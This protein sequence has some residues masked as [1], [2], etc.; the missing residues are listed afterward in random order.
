[1]LRS[2]RGPFYLELCSK[3]G[4]LLMESMN[5]AGLKRV[6]FGQFPSQLVN[7]FE[8]RACP[9][10]ILPFLFPDSSGGDPVVALVIEAAVSLLESQALAVEGLA[11]LLPL[12]FGL[13]SLV[14]GEVPCHAQLV[15]LS[16]LSVAF[17]VAPIESGGDGLE[18]S[19]HL[20]EFGALEVIHGIDRVPEAIELL[21]EVVS[22]VEAIDAV[23]RRENVS[24]L[25]DPMF[26]LL[27]AGN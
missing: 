12:L 26:P 22:Q 3:N 4:D 6:L 18:L 27:V 23:E 13:M 10:E 20:D 25:N 17:S 1:M 9:F 19:P 21:A 7:L 2:P 5:L 24:K 15:R 11:L 16:A 14:A 8:L